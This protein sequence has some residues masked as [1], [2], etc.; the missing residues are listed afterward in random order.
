MPNQKLLFLVVFSISQ[1]MWNFDTLGNFPLTVMCSNPL[2]P[3]RTIP[4]LLDNKISEM[5]NIYPRTGYCG[6]HWCEAFDSARFQRLNVAGELFVMRKA[7]MKSQLDQDDNLF[8]IQLNFFKIRI[9]ISRTLMNI[10][11]WNLKQKM[12]YRWKPQICKDFV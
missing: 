3:W 5:Y 6:C 11:S 7:V 4:E 10:F 8:T 12:N 9:K 2:G 1:K